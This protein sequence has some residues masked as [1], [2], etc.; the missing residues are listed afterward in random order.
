MKLYI[1]ITLVYVV[2]FLVAHYAPLAG[3]A[4]YGLLTV[5]F[6]VAAYRTRNEG[7]LYS[8]VDPQCITFGMLCAHFFGWAFLLMALADYWLTHKLIARYEAE[9]P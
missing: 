3:A 7:F 6:L 1:Y 4:A 5:A 8:A 9:E 2:L